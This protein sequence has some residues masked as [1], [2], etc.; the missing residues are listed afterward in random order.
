LCA[1]LDIDR[2]EV[3]QVYRGL[4]ML[5]VED[6]RAW[7]GSLVRELQLDVRTASRRDGVLIG[8]G[9]QVRR[10]YSRKRGE[11]CRWL[12]VIFLHSEKRLGINRQRWQ[13][14]IR[15]AQEQRLG[16]HHRNWT[17]DEQPTDSVRAGKPPH[18][19]AAK[20]CYN[21]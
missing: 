2:L 18:F 8:D 14:N 12:R 21:S 19:L 17:T 20:P 5:T 6:Y 13:I 10:S 16:Q 11:K 3:K 1:I 7:M 15:Q 4:A 9:T